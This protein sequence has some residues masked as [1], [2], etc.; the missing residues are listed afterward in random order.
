MSKHIVVGAGPIGT[1]TALL[2]AERGE[3]VVMV[4][5]SGS[6]PTHPAVTRTAA[7][8]SSSARMAELATGAVAIYNCAN[9][10]YHRW[11]TDW[12]PLA[13]AVLTAAERSE[14]V[15]ATVSNVYDT[16]RSPAR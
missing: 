3:E 11:P 5:R 9:P 4:T 2:L 16:G 13:H 14:A 7:D 1:A 6:G 15:L 10:A 8:A 12:P